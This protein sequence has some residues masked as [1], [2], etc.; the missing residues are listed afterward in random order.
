MNKSVE[1]ITGGI[2]R[3]DCA[4]FFFGEPP[5]FT[6]SRLDPVFRASTASHFKPFGSHKIIVGAVSEKRASQITP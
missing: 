4:R 1:R 6:A 3:S 2:Q 5:T